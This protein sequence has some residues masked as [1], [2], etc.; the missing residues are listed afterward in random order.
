MGAGHGAGGS[1][2]SRPIAQARPAGPGRRRGRGAEHLEA[3][4]DLQ[5]DKTIAIV[6]REPLC[7]Y[8]V[9]SEFRKNRAAAGAAFLASAGSVVSVRA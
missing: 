3:R 8:V 5:H 7:R 6:M 9:L 2:A 1:R 4:P